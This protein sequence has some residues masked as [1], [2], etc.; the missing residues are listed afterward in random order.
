VHVSRD[1]VVEAGLNHFFISV[2]SFQLLSYLNI[3]VEHDRL[4]HLAAINRADGPSNFVIQ[5]GYCVDLDCC[6]RFYNLFHSYVFTCDFLLG[7]FQQ[8]LLVD[9][10]T[11]INLISLLR[12]HR[13]LPL[14]LHPVISRTFRFK[15]FGASIQS[16]DS[17]ANVW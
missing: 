5:A 15:E 3:R 17:K 9:G 6:L 7:E 11:T 13:N 4:A 8:R 1:Q 14:F 2:Q 12:N 16:A 10:I